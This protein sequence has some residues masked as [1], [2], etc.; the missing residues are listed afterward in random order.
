[1]AFQAQVCPNCGAPLKLVGN[2]CSFCKVPLA[3]VPEPGITAGLPEAR[4][5]APPAG[6]PS[7]PFSMR[8]DDVFSIKKRGTVVTG[9]I[10]AGTLRV[11]DALVIDGAAGGR[12][13]ACR[14]IEAFRKTMDSATVGET[15]GLMLDGVEKSDITSGD[16]LRAP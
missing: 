13:T 10:N 9:R 15:V 12:S 5:A 4:P 8:V 2:Q 7:A 11:G 3:A 1:M 6:D 14:A 16:W